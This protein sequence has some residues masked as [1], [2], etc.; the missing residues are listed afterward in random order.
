MRDIAEK[1]KMFEVHIIVARMAL[2]GQAVEQD[3]EISIKY[4]LDHLL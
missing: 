2:D 3:P 1:L 4:G